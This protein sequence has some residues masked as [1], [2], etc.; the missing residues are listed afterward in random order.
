MKSGATRQA[1]ALVASSCGQVLAIVEERQIARARLEQWLDVA[2]ER[3]RVDTFG[4]PRPHFLRQGAQGQ[5]G[6][7]LEKARMLH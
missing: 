3:F 4:E 6:R 5:G 2:D 1:A 7:S